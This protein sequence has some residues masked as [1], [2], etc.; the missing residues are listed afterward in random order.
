MN[1]KFIDAKQAKEVHQYH[2]IKRKLYRTTTAIW[3]NK[4]C[5]DRWI[6]P[7]YISI[8]VSGNNK[9]RKQYRMLHVSASTSKKQKLNEQLYNAHLKCAKTWNNWRIIQPIIDNKLQQEMEAHYN[10]LNK[11]LDNIQSK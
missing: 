7:K 10:N 5:R 2:Y 3:Y 6:T 8:R 9:V 4:T 11:K 1:I